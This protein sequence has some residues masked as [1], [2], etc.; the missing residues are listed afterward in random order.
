MTTFYTY[1][2]PTPGCAKLLSVLCTVRD[3]ALFE[4]ADHSRQP[5][6]T[7]SDDQNAFMWATNIPEGSEWSEDVRFTFDVGVI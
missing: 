1:P 7:G 4:G 3:A 6:L 2:E 5:V